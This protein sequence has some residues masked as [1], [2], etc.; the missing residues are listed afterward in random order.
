M[1]VIR[2]RG[3]NSYKISHMPKPTKSDLTAKDYWDSAQI[4]LHHVIDG[5]IKYRN[6]NIDLINIL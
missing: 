5:N 4:Y 1:V 3:K 6:I 2:K